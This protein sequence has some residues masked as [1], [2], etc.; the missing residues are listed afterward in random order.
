MRVA[1]SADNLPR[2]MK[3]SAPLSAARAV[4]ALAASVPGEWLADQ[5]RRQFITRNRRV[6]AGLTA[7]AIAIA[8]AVGAGVRP[9]GSR[10]AR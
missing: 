3:V 6:A 4:S 10:P 5:V 9:A 8:V 2:V 7:L 1:Q